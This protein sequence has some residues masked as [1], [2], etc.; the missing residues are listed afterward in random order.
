MGAK[1]VWPDVDQSESATSLQNPDSRQ[2]LLQTGTFRG[3][4]PALTWTR[5]MPIEYEPEFSGDDADDLETDED[6]SD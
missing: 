3:A 6:F 4:W 5:S 1:A 2:R